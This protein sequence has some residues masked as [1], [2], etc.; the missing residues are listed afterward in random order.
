MNDKVIRKKALSDIHYITEYESNGKRYWA[1]HEEVHVGT[2][3]IPRSKIFD[4]DEFESFLEFEKF[5]WYGIIIRY[6]EDS[7][8]LSNPIYAAV[9]NDCLRLVQERL[10]S[11]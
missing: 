5:V 8:W 2:H 9:W 7:V 10:R 1:F 6:E 4:G 3:A 11:F